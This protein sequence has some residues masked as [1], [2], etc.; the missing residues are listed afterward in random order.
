[1]FKKI[2]SAINRYLEA[3]AKENKELYGN[4]RMD[5]CNLNKTN[6]KSGSKVRN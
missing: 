4:G 2:K 1:M 3:L 5:C 6:D